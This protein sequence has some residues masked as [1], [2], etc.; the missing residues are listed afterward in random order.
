MNPNV[1]HGG[2]LCGSVRYE[3]T[4]PPYDITHC[5]CSDCRRSSGAPFVTWASFRRSGF[6]FTTG[7]PREMQWA[8]RLRSFCAHCGTP[9][10]FLAGAEV[11]EIDVTVCS[12]DEPAIVTP[13]DHTWIEDR[14]PWIRLADALPAYEQKRPA[15]PPDT[16]LG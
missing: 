2:C 11:D 8:G 13:A 16:R 12:F 14:L 9:L 7:R 15:T 6:R 3:S 5:H 4:G 1:I 10:T